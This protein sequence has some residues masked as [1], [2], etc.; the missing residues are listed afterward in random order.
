M[1]N[2]WKLLLLLLL[3]LAVSCLS[4][5]AESAKILK[6]LPQHLDL[7]GR[8]SLSP[9]L[10]ERDAYQA[11]LRQTPDQRSGLR[12]DVQWKAKGRP[13]G[14]LVLRLELRTSQS[15][16]KEPLIVE[17]K[18]EPKKWFTTWS[19]LQV[20]GEPFQSMGELIAW[21]VSLRAGGQVVAE[22]KSFLW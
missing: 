12:F 22:Q 10:F 16:L 9:S 5:Q 14:E 21:R 18:V 19:A 2:G 3:L 1:S 13:A 6:V 4:V 11:F 17:H 8:H 20:S 15:H 7:K